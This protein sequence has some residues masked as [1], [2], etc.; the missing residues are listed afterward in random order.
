[1]PLP[2]SGE[3]DIALVQ[4]LSGD[5]ALMA[6]V[7]DGVYFNE[8]PQ[9]MENFVIVSLVEGLV[10]AQMGAPT[11]RRAAE[12]AEYIVKAVL[13]NGSSAD[14][15]EAAARID[16]LLEDQTIP[17]DG[18]TCLSIVRS[19]RIHDTEPDD[20]D[21]TIRWQH[22]GGFYRILAAPGGTP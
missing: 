22:R 1:M 19:K 14:A 11:E 3:I 16:D 18:F 9:G 15:R 13:L 2:D 5:A 12:D 20:V 8:A 4:V 7:P 6:L 21:T 17:I 10:R